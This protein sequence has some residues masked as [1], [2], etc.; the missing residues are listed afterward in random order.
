MGHGLTWLRL[1]PGVSQL[2]AYF[3]A[4]AGEAGLGSGLLFGSPLS[5]QH[6]VAAALVM[7]LV[8][9]LAT[10]T[11]VGMRRAADGG[12]VPDTRLSLRNLIELALDMLYAQMRRIIGED[13][14]RYFP[15]VG[16]LALFIF[17]SNVLGLVPGFTPPTD[18]W[19][20]TFACG[21]FVF[22]YYNWH[23]LRA[24]GLGHI[25]HMANPVGKWWGW[26]LAPLM[27]P[28]ELVSHIA[29]PASLSIRLAANMVGD[30][31]VVTAFLGLV[32][33]LVPLPFMVLGLLV[34]LVQTLVFCLLTTI[35]ISLAISGEHEEHEGAEA[36]A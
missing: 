34:S 25:A 24:H 35:Y 33:I 30:H 9:L 26:I 13:A 23:G 3:T 21:I 16:T 36:S 29:R 8:L 1:L 4:R 10:T 31:A 12:L 27:F 19:N 32:P 15:V 17:V 6:V 20:T 11:R 18:N 28:I 2:E 14:P 22:L 5:I 7:A